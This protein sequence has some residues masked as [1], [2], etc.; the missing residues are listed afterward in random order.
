MSACRGRE[1]RG[2][3][4]LG[5]AQLGAVASRNECQAPGLVF[6]SYLLSGFALPTR[7][8]IAHFH[9]RTRR[10]WEAEERAPRAARLIGKGVA[11]S[12]DDADAPL[13]LST[14]GTP[15]T[16]EAFGGKETV[17]LTLM[18]WSNN[19]IDPSH[20]LVT[21]SEGFTPR[22]HPQ[23]DISGRVPRTSATNYDGRCDGLAFHRRICYGVHV[24]PCRLSF[25]PGL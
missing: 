17:G 14:D 3:G 16:H 20:W 1:T 2:E 11:L 5:A 25:P 8:I 19:N 15:Q 21:R 9:A 13:R 22:A 10:S 6:R 24:N 7:R 4:A 18:R 12:I 23:T